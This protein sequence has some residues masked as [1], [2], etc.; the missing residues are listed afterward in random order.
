MNDCLRS[1]RPEW[2]AKW[3]NC[4]E[5]LT[6]SLA[7]GDRLDLQGTTDM[8]GKVAVASYMITGGRRV[9]SSWVRGLHTPVLI[10]GTYPPL[11]IF[12]SFLLSLKF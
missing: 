9:N 5:E 11:L 10:C 3:L 1:D 8:Q 2:L 12:A 4:R 6:S 7:D